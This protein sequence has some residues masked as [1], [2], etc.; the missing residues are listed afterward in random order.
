MLAVKI[1]LILIAKVKGNN[2]RTLSSAGTLIQKPVNEEQSQE[3]SAAEGIRPNP[4]TDMQ[5]WV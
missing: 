1:Q 3:I 4:Y 5:D 2:D